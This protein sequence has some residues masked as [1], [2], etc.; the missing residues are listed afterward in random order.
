MNTLV[1][2][3]KALAE[4]SRLRLLVLCNQGE[5]SVSELVYILGQSQPRVSRHLKILCDAGLLQKIREGSWMLYRI[6][7]ET[8][9]AA[10][11]QKIL[12]SLP[13]N[14][15]VVALDH[16]RLSSVQAERNKSAAD[17]F[18]F[19]ARSYYSWCH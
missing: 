16:I 8:E 17:Y 3:L 7:S 9:A 6:T 4:P 18:R 15:P 13:K 12:N 1:K 11:A 10:I 14:D 5:F 2:I 19:S